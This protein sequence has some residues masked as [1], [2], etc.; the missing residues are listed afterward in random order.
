MRLMSSNAARRS[1]GLR[2]NQ[3]AFS[4][5]ESDRRPIERA[6][7]STLI[8]STS[9]ISHED[10]PRFP[11]GQGA[12]FLYRRI[13]PKRGDW[14]RCIEAA[15]DENCAPAELLLGQPG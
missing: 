14:L 9:S 8:S 3:Y 4:S 15:G 1:A 13:Y 2:E 12:V 11:G 7:L 6:L 5:E 10:I